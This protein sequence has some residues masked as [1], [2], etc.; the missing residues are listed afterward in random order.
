MNHM[1]SWECDSAEA[2]SSCE[3][4]ELSAPVAGAKREKPTSPPGRARGASD[5]RRWPSGRDVAAN[6]GDQREQTRRE[7][8]CP[9]RSKKSSSAP[10]RSSR[11]RRDR[12]AGPLTDFA[13]GRRSSG[14]PVPARPRPGCGSAIPVD[15]VVGCQWDP[16]ERTNRAGTM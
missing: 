16:I 2:A 15:L 1:R 11:T 14:R 4:K 10:I 8:E 13:R 6:D 5:G 3:A 12:S 9:P 7:S